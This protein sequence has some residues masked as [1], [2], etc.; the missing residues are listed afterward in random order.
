MRTTLEIDDAV[1]A[2]AKALAKDSHSSVGAALSEL[3]RRG[4]APTAHRRARGF[5]VFDVD[6][7]AAPITLDLVNENRD[8]E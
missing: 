8:G 7:A 3:A 4:L 2:A 6:Q 1:L 5:P